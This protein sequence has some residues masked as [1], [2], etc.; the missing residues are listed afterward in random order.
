MAGN[1]NY[2]KGGRKPYGTKVRVNEFH[3][4][5]PAD[6][7]KAG[8]WV[9]GKEVAHE[10]TVV[11]PS[12]SKPDTVRYEAIRRRIEDIP[13]GAKVYESTSNLQLYGY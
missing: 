7:P 10:L 5:D 4:L 1:E 6:L 11:I 3:G 9:R 12:R 13:R 8:D 2:G